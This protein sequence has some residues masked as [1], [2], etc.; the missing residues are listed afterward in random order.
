M[1]DIRESLLII[2]Q[3]LIIWRIVSV[4]WLHAV[5]LFCGKLVLKLNHSVLYSFL[6]FYKK[7]RKMNSL[8]RRHHYKAL[9]KSSHFSK[10]AFHTL[11]LYK[12][13]FFHVSLFPR[14]WATCRS[15]TLG[16]TL[17]SSQLKALALSQWRLLTFRIT[18]S[19]SPCFIESFIN[20]G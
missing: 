20:K 16:S 8:Q 10:V 15:E 1:Q 13:L 11:I 9:I 14:W 6:Q 2:K 12:Q 4:F 5:R 19:M 3:F 7:C 18:I 17:S